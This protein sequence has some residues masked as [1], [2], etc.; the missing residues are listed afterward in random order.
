MKEIK[1]PDGGWGTYEKDELEVRTEEIMV[2][3]ITVQQI[4]D[5]LEET[6]PPIGRVNKRDWARRLAAHKFHLEGKLSGLSFF[7]KLI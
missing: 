7:T 5:E 6:R 3:G 4:K 2:S 1:Q